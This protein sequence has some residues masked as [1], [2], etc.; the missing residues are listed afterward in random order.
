MMVVS[1]LLIILVML[2]FIIS[3]SF[4]FWLFFITVIAILNSGLLFNSLSNNCRLYQNDPVG[5]VLD[6]KYI[7]FHSFMVIV[8]VALWIKWLTDL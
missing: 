6:L 3:D 1:V 7:V 8:C 4:D 5:K 2:V